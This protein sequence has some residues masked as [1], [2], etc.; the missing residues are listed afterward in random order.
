MAFSTH[1]HRCR[2]PVTETGQGM[3]A[4]S[5]ERMIN[6]DI[7]NRL[8]RARMLRGWGQVQLGEAV[9]VSYQQIQ[10]YESGK[11]N[12]NPSMLIRLANVLK[13]GDAG[14]FFAASVPSAVDMLPARH[15]FLMQCMQR[16]ERE[17]P[18]AYER[19]C[20]LVAE[21]VAVLDS[22]ESSEI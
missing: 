2:A 4:Q 14:Y 10:K 16:L 19:V 3:Q 22:E 18:A 21:L 5:P 13:V 8:R 7:G 20:N 1:R 11:N 6:S 15:I 17:K 9:G 12:I